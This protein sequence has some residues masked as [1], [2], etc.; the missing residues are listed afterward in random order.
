MEEIKLYIISDNEKEN[1]Q[2]NY[3]NENSIDNENE[4]D[5]NDIKEEYYLWLQSLIRFMRSCNYRKVLKDIHKREAGFKVLDIFDLWKYKILKVKAIFKIIRRKFRKYKMEIQKEIPS[6]ISSVEFWFNQIFFILEELTSIFIVKNENNEI[7]LDSKKVVYPIQSIMQSYIELI[8]LLIKYCYL[9]SDVVP[10]ILSYISMVT[11][12][13]VP[14]MSYIYS[15]KSIY[16]LQN[17]LLLRTKLYI[18]NKN[19]SQALQTQKLAIKLG[20]RDLILR[21][22]EETVVNNLQS[23]KYISK[24]TYNNL[25]CFILSLYL[26]GVTY[27]HL[28]N[29]RFATQSYS[30]CKL[31]Y[32]KYLVKNE[33]KFG[34]FL[35]KLD[36]ESKL[37]IEICIDI[38]IIIKKRN[39]INKR[40][41]LKKK[42]KN[43][44]AR[45]RGNYKTIKYE[46]K[47]EKNYY[48]KFDQSKNRSV[49]NYPFPYKK[50]LR[51][52][53]VIKG[54]KDKSRAAKLEKYLNNVGEHLYVEEEN[55]NNNLIHK[56]SKSK[57]ILSTVTMIDNLL[58]KDFQNVLMKMDNIEIT[59]PKDEIKSMIEKIILS[60]RV[61]LFNSKIEKKNRQRSAIIFRKNNFIN[62]NDKT[63]DVKSSMIKDSINNNNNSKNKYP[64]SLSN[65]KSKGFYTCS[66]K[67][68]KQKNNLSVSQRMPDNYQNNSRIL[69]ENDSKIN[70]SAKKINYQIKSYFEKVYDK[71]HYNNNFGKII[72]YPIDRMNF[73]RS[74]IRKK[75]YL[76]K[77]LDR[78]FDFQKHLL[79]SK[80]NEIMDI[81]EIDF[82]DQKSAFFSA[83]RDFDKILNVQKSN[84]GDKF[85]SNLISMKQIKVNNNNNPEQVKEKK[86]KK[87]D[88]F[89]LKMTKIYNKNNKNKNIEDISEITLKKAI[90][91]KNEDDMKKLSVECAELSHRKKQLESQRRK[92]ILN[93]TKS[94]IKKKIFQ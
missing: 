51:P 34:I 63:I 31:I 29:R 17:L 32:T 47:K 39:E 21:S 72:K 1:D 64:Y 46:E 75:R 42:L 8:F 53:K 57:Y 83:E 23:R 4:L 10:E 13:F 84:Y 87:N 56:Y 45:F 80:R 68:L 6:K 16:L 14:Y 85:I 48:D 74:Q 38:K 93:V 19:Y 44:Y 11:N 54:I 69:K 40:K 82:Y 43:S 55:M 22:D 20:L 67:Q 94:K 27:E 52:R 41:E 61:K 7:N 58:S 62:E 5:I 36:Y 89:F 76:D 28:G 73:S 90:D 30:T 49:I 79:S 50:I 2:V 71:N 33:E 9:K 78:E 59:K 3:L 92:F 91:Q 60:K 12:F 35:N 88:L 18:Q 37:N 86:H 15:N 66:P 24:K 77:Y 70:D 81:T 25:V 26:R 65:K